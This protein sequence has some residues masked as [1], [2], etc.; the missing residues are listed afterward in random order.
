MK[1]TTLFRVLTFILMIGLLASCS[2]HT[3]KPSN[4]GGDGNN[5]GGNN[6]GGNNG[7][8]G[9]TASYY[10]KAKMDGVT[11]NYAGTVKASRYVQ[12][13]GTHVLRIQG[14]KGNGS[15][16]EMEVIILSA[17][18]ATTGQYTE[19]EH[20][21]YAIFGIY[22]PQN[23]ADDNG[24]YMAGQ[25]STD[26]AAPYSINIT[27]ITSKYVKGTFSGAFFDVQGSGSNEKKFT[28]GEF[29]APIQ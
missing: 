19:G 25:Q 26:N 8:G 29:V 20:E 24:I 13:D 15:T 23:R 9:Q 2:K 5:G 16:D 28:N 18:D 10:V 21:T 12:D 1:K 7:G 14:I 3:D 27:E 22:A 17:E 6:G 11:L 4:S